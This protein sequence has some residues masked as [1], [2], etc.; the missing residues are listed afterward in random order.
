MIKFAFGMS[1]CAFIVLMAQQGIS[2]EGCLGVAASVIAAY[3]FDKGVR[4]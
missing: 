4:V 3:V 1:A 2:V